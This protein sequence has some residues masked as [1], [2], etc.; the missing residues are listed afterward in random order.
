MSEATLPLSGTVATVIT[1]RTIKCFHTNNIC[2]CYRLLRQI[3]NEV[4]R[5]TCL[6]TFSSRCSDDDIVVGGYFIPAGTPI[7]IA[8]GVSMKNETVWKN[9]EKLDT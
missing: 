6:T 1:I 2:I 4:L 9:T 5:M 7:F 3:L 8:L